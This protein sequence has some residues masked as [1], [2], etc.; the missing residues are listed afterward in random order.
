MP[1]LLVVVL[2]LAGLWLGYRIYS[3]GVEAVLPFAQAGDED[4]ER[5]EDDL[6]EAALL[7]G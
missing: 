7:P 1:R 4:G 3:E 6:E 2:L 5:P